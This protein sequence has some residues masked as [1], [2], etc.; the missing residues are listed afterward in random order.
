MGLVASRRRQVV[1]EKRMCLRV[2]RRCRRCVEVLCSG[3]AEPR[4]L[5]SRLE[6]LSSDSAIGLPPHLVAVDVEGDAGG[7]CS[8]Q[9]LR[10]RDVLPGSHS[11]VGRRRSLAS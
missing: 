5:K 4:D 9:H 7:V 6:I 2:M 11:I 10:R 1:R 3:C 8:A